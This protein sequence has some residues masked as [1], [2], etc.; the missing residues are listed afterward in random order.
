MDLKEEMYQDMLEESR[1]EEYLEHKLRNDYDNF[2]Q[3]FENEIADLYEAIDI[4]RKLHESYG[5]E[6]DIKDY[7]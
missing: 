6:F 5:W 4:L 3:H 1:R 7:E 2:E